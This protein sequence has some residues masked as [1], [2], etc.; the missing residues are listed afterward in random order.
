M[1]KKYTS[2]GESMACCKKDKKAGETKEKPKTEKK[3]EKKEK[4]GK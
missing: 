4:K 2:G 3:T 1:W